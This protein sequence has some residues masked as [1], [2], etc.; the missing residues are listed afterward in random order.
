M[1]S[2]DRASS[3]RDPAEEAIMVSLTVNGHHVTVDVDPQTPLIYVL[4]NDL[5]L[6][7]PKLGCAKGQ[8]G[9]CT[10]LVDGRAERACLLPVNAVEGGKAVV[11]LEGF[12]TPDRPHPLQS[13][14]IAEQAL[15]CGYCTSGMIMQAAAL[16]AEKS[17]PTDREVRSALAANLCRCGS[18]P[19]VVRAVL[20]A[21]KSGV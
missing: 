2:A 10:V 17:Q 21:A 18:H 7:G 16:L 4:R 15:Q 5:A 20:R 3:G 8:C 13:A 12:G 1:L 14:F 9:A 6:N 19:R 11:T